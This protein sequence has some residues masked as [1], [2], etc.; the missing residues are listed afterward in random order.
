LPVPVGRPNRANMVELS[1]LRSRLAPWWIVLML[2]YSILGSGSV[3]FARRNRNIPQTRI[4]HAIVAP[5]AS[6]LSRL[7]SCVHRL[8]ATVGDDAVVLDDLRP[9]QRMVCSR[10]PGAGRRL[11]GLSPSRALYRGLTTPPPPSCCSKY[12]KSQHAIH[13]H[14]TDPQQSI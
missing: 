8:L 12:P 14:R 9:L 4:R 5:I 2:L 11:P 3:L 10:F 1:Y 6:R 13:Q 7:C